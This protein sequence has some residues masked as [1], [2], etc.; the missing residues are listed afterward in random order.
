M[1][2]K[3]VEKEIEK[4]LEDEVKESSD[5][6]PCTTGAILS[7]SSYRIKRLNKNKKSKGKEDLK[8]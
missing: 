6:M 4:E 7:A 5:E 3:E 8:N 2:A 1:V